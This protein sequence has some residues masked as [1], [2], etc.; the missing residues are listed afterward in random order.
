MAMVG[1]EI[2]FYLRQIRNDKTGRYQIGGSALRVDVEP[3]RRAADPE[4]I[5]AWQLSTWLPDPSGA[6]RRHRLEYAERPL[7]TILDALR[8]YARRRGYAAAFVEKRSGIRTQILPS[9]PGQPIA[10]CPP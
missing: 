3:V 4:R 1:R 10:G 8:D 7:P 9:P 2:V 6:E 5:V